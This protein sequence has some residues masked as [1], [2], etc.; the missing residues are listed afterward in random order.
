MRA[1]SLV[2][3]HVWWGP[4]YKKDSHECEGFI[5]LLQ[6]QRW[7]RLVHVTN[8]SKYCRKPLLVSIFSSQPSLLMATGGKGG[9]CY[10]LLGER[11]VKTP[12][13]SSMVFLLAVSLATLWLSL[14]RR[15]WEQKMGYY[16]LYFMTAAGGDR[17]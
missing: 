12:D 1:F 17:L 7:S 16:F 8:L 10:G 15:S 13:A 5:I 11:E 4:C 14:L 2:Y 9:G 3:T 6:K